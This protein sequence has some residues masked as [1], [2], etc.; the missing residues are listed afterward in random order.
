MEDVLIFGMS[1]F[2]LG[3][4]CYLLFI[5]SDPL[6]RVGAR[7]GRLLRLPEDV[8]A[9]TFQALATSGPEIVMAIIAATT[10]ITQSA[11]A[12]LETG[13]KSCSGC[14]NM[15]FSA[16]DNLLG[17][18]CLGII[19]MLAKR[20]VKGDEPIE[21]PTSGKIGLMFYICASSCLSIFIMDGIITETEAWVLM[22]I[23]ITFVLSQFFIP[24]ILNRVQNNNGSAALE[25]RDDDDDEDEAPMPT[26]SSG[27]FCDFFKNGFVYAF[28]VFALVIFVRECLGATFKM[29]M[30]G[31]VSLGGV[32]I[33]F[34]SYVSSFPEFMMTYRYAKAV[35]KGALLGM[36][37]GSNVID[38][39]FAGFR[40]MWLH[41]PMAVYTT[42]RFP[43]LLPVYI[44]ALPAFALLS[45]VGLW[46]KKVKFKHAYPLMVFYIAYIV[47]GF[48]LL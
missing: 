27:W 7:L 20:T 29:A 6:E 10:F 16:M 14:L 44:W 37:F 18:G 43:Q 23:G 28:L 40:A 41:E 39:A 48:V 1:L 22:I 35:K 30:V 3:A 15:C 47:S 9:S 32:L 46:T 13:E 11:W 19:Y 2:V 17:I 42:G 33:M 45:L 38:L 36:L 26:T 21:I 5:T 12:A 31:V 24:G 4:S 34:T 8:I 25:D